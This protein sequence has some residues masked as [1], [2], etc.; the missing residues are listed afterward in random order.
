MS[1]ALTGGFDSCLE[2]GGPVLDL[3]AA[4]ALAAILASL[5]D[6]ALTLTPPAGGQALAGT[7]R[8][9]PSSAHVGPSGD[10]G[11][12]R[13]TVR[14]VATLGLHI[15]APDQDQLALQAQLT[16]P[17]LPLVLS[18][19][20]IRDGTTPSSFAVDLSSFQVEVSARPASVADLADLA[21][22]LGLA[23]DTI[24]ATL[25]PDAPGRPGRRGRGY[26]PRYPGSSARR[27]GPAVRA[28][29]PQRPDRADGA[30]DLPDRRH[31]GDP[32]GQ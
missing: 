27:A 20:A 4:P 2:L 14:L 12:G 11:D 9:L 23:P 6:V 10:S 15:T 29:G 24:T 8:L 19:P 26:Q 30:G 3:Q 5:R 18:P 32:P 28:A 25:E 16:L 7:V 17:G 13:L 31:D 1:A 21:R 22:R